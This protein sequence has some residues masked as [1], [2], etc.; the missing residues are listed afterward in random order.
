MARG[1]LMK[2]LITSYGRDDAFRAVVEQII[3]E[4]EHKNNR[5][6]ARALRTSL[7]R[8]GD[9]AAPAR[10]SKLLPFPDEARDFIQRVEQKRSFADLML[11]EEN[12]EL[13]AEI[14]REFRQ[15]DRLRRHGLDLRTK[16][17]F[18]GPPGTGKTICAEAFAGELGLPFFHVRLDSLVSSYL[19]ETASNIRKTFEFARRQPCVLF[20]DEFDALA[21]SREDA[22]ES[23]E[24]RRVVNSL[25]MFIE[26]IEP[27]GF[28]IAATNLADQLDPAVWR[29][30][31]EVVWFDLP[32]RDMI[33]AYLRRAFR[34][35]KAEFD[36]ADYAAALDGVSYAELERIAV[37]AIRRSTVDG[38]RG[39][40][41]RH[42]AAALRNADR[43]RARAA[44][45]DER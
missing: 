26:Q 23:G 25:L 32:G 36:P 22:G 1:E 10:P 28:L 43:R 19:G 24:L 31:D 2:K 41:T 11:S 20:F 12:T 35:V 16:L 45:T 9:N 21:R 30:F 6:L 27:G 37:G 5:V 34:N 42:L 17:M 15:A 4:E 39:V 14:V 8:L 40:S 44:T 3:D 38:A 13:F 29:R 7:E 33:E 18:C